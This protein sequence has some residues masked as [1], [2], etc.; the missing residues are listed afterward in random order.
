MRITPLVTKIADSA[1]YRIAADGG[2][3]NLL[4]CGLV[5]DLLIGDLDSVVQED[6]DI[7]QNAGCEIRQ[8]PV[9]KDE[10]DLELALLAAV[11]RGSGEIV[12]FAAF[13]G[14]L[15]HT[16]GN[17]SLLSH[18]KLRDAHIQLENGTE[19]VFIVRSGEIIHGAPGD[20]ISLLPLTEEV[21][22][23]TTRGL[24]YPLSSETI[25]EGKSRGMSNVML[26]KDIQILFSSG[27]LLCVHTRSNQEE[28]E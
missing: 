25:Y 26:D 19:R 3:K 28:Y 20:L 2:L 14:R 5:P 22:K 17:I 24:Q 18:P 23:V 7:A 21:G 11:N 13:G 9:E 15:D 12:V 16:L 6:V 4:A 1:D 8:F 10:T 27:R